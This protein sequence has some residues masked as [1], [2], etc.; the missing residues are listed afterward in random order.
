MKSDFDVII[1][2]SGP[3]GVSAAYPLVQSGLSVLMIDGGKTPKSDLNTNSYIKTRFE[4]THQWNWM[5]GKNYHA[6]KNTNAISPK[7]RI[8]QY[9][10]VFEE[11]NSVN[12][13]LSSGFSAVGSLAKG[14]L[15]NAWG[16]GVAA[17]SEE[18]ACAFPFEYSEIVESYER[19]G[20]R[21]GISG[22]SNDDLRG[23]FGVDEYSMPPIAMD[24]LHSYLYEK[25]QLK[26]KKINAFGAEIGRSRVAALS[27]DHG[28]RLACNL[29][30]NCLWG[31]SRKSLY[32][33]VEDLDLLRRYS[34]FKEISGLY[35]DELIRVQG[36]GCISGKL[37]AT[38]ERVKYAAKYIVLAAGTLASTRLVL[39][40]IGMKKSIRM[41]SSPTA[42]FMITIPKK[43]G[44]LR[45][46]SFGLGQMS[47][48]LNLNGNIKAF[49]STF[50]T[51]GI[52]VYEFLKFL[53]LHKR[54]GVDF[55]RTLLN[56]CLVGNLFLPGSLS[57]VKVQL[58]SDG[59]LKI[60]GEYSNL[61]PELW[62]EARKKLVKLY[63][64]MG[65]ILLPGSFSVGSVGADIHYSGTFPMKQNPIFGETTSMGEVFGLDG[66]YVVDGSCL[67]VLSE[68]S[69]TLTIM[70][71]ADR[72][73][74]KLAQL[75]REACKKV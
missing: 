60:D 17:L 32:S 61:V 11:F 30:G 5:L 27:M 41:L 19:V 67:P 4:D 59:F 29:S 13:I 54:F 3:A 22:S 69:H 15:S 73:G 65:A 1:V 46:S 53:P 23:Y 70:A 68:K 56:S 62:D 35:V 75:F 20:R 44:L 57:E 58:Q 12:K 24:E 18:E 38:N 10:Y 64:M 31:C 63:W 40:A 48:V 66:V 9:E 36:A 51:A 45:K 74:R 42:A 16:C 2:G 14:G 7:L 8:P 55:L 50:S 72:I 37:T 71:N 34:N 43:I 6:L 39:S 21:I 47:Y 26:R 33:A 49:G 25:Y 28:G 52:P